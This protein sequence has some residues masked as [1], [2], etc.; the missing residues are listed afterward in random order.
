MTSPTHRMRAWLRRSTPAIRLKSSAI[1]RGGLLRSLRFTGVR[2]R[3]QENP[4]ASP[5][6]GPARS[7]PRLARGGPQPLDAADARHADIEQAV[8]MASLEELDAERPA[9]R[10]RLLAAAPA[11]DRTSAAE[12]GDQVA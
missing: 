12:A 7:V 2:R 3:R 9:Q 10:H 1:L 11:Q 8:D 4:P 6:V 5:P